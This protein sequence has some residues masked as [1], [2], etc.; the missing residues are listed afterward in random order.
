MGGAHVDAIGADMDAAGVG[1]EEAVERRLDRWA[2]ARG[3]EQGMSEVVDHLLIAHL[4]PLQQVQDVVH[5][6]PRKVLRLDALE[7]GPASLHAQHAGLATKTESQPPVTAESRADKLELAQSGND[8]SV[9]SIQK[10]ANRQPRA[11]KTSSDEITL[12]LR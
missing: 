9:A 10:L 7:V 8:L 1:G 4:V 5:P 3:L 6:D 11:E 2:R 12:S